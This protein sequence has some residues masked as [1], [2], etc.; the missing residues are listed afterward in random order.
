[1]K[2]RPNVGNERDFRGFFKIF[3]SPVVDFC[4]ISLLYEQFL[5]L[6]LY[7]KAVLFNTLNDTYGKITE[8]NCLNFIFRGSYDNIKDCTHHLEFQQRTDIK[9]NI[10]EKGEL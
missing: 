1:M 8:I 5:R 7:F 10:T 6:F 9:V 4:Q 3:F 2:E